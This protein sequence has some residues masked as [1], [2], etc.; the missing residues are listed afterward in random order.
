MGFSACMWRGSGPH[1]R[2]GMS[3]CGSG[4]GCGG[5]LAPTLAV[6]LGLPAHGA[7]CPQP[8]PHGPSVTHGVSVTHG[9]C[10]RR[11]LPASARV[12]PRPDAP[13]RV[14]GRWTPSAAMGARAPAGC[15]TWGELG[16][17]RAWVRHR[18]RCGWPPPQG[19]PEFS[20][21]PQ[22]TGPGAWGIPSLQIFRHISVPPA[23]PSWLGGKPLPSTLSSP[24]PA[25]RKQME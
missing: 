14:C 20:P 5:D 18:H 3:G 4:R 2:R 9:A 15:Q 19:G 21:G 7:C 6:G 1:A 11:P 16:L 13:V 12:D 10:A 17:P 23:F 8:L 22:S 25:L 24:F